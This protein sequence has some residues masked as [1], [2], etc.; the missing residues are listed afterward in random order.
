[1]RA[2]GIGCIVWIS[3]RGRRAGREAS[4]RET[5]VGRRWWEGT[6]FIMG[7]SDDTPSCPERNDCVC[8]C[9]SV[10]MCVQTWMFVE[11]VCPCLPASLWV[12]V[13]SVGLIMRITE[14]KR[15][16]GSLPLV[17]LSL[18][19]AVMDWSS[20]KDSR[21]ETERKTESL[22]V[23]KTLLYLLL[24]IV[25]PLD[26]WGDQQSVGCGTEGQD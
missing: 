24:P 16:A 5:M 22:A 4:R 8:V 18:S 12:L 14:L 21:T 7:R 23:S 10:C 13:L 1:M 26:L 19:E 6:T 2:A 3:P 11:Y 9:F 20:W 17:H 25:N 15:H